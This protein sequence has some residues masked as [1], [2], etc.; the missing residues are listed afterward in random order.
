MPDRKVI[1]GLLG[2]VVEYHFFSEN[3]S[4]SAGK[5]L[6][7]IREG[8]RMRMSVTQISHDR[9]CAH[10]CT[11][12]EFAMSVSFCLFECYECVL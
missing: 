6:H 5:K 12:K 10:V 1:D 8:V 2:E 4:G 7:S 9:T 11:S 3:Q